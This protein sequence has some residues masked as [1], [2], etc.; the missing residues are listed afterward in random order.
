MFVFLFAAHAKD[1][2]A[3]EQEVQKQIVQSK[4]VDTKLEEILQALAERSAEDARA[5]EESG[6]IELKPKDCGCMPG[7]EECEAEHDH[8][9]TA[10]EPPTLEKK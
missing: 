2:P 5:I 4:E 9:D 3:M 10:D 6:V 7:D 1:P 8:E